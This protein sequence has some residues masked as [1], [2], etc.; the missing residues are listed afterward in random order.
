MVYDNA[1][2]F[3]RSRSA[4]LVDPE[5]VSVAYLRAF[6]SQDLGAIGDAETKAIYTEFGLEMKNEAANGVVAD[7]TTS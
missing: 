4:L 5:Y 7:L 2:N 1:S 3:S 6:E